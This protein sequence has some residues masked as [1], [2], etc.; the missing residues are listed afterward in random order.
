[1]DYVYICRSGENEELRYSIRSVVKHATYDN[2]WV[3]GSKP[4]W[5]IGNYIEVDD[6]G[7]KF[8]NIT[9]CYRV[10]PSIGALS[11]DFVLMNDDFF[12]LKPLGKMPIFY[13]GTLSNKIDKHISVS[14]MSQYARVLIKAKKELIKQGIKDPLCYDI[15]V[16]MVFNKSMLSYMEY[17]NNAPRSMY[18]NIYNLGGVQIKD[19]KIY[20]NNSEFN[21]NESHFVSSEDNSFKLIKE[22][23][24]NLFP[25]PSIY[26]R[27]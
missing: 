14:G 10:L 2:I 18:G 11:D 25:Q 1:M 16:P 21:I 8:D 20:K 19:V 23:L 27:P 7:N 5:Y 17:S 3:I 26:E 6:I 15:H 4:D 13:D 24:H 9:N 12:I 22:E